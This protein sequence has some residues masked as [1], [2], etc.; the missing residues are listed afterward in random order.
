MEIYSAAAAADL[1]GLHKEKMIQLFKDWI[2]FF[3][4]NLLPAVSRNDAIAL[5]SSLSYLLSHSGRSRPSE[6][7]SYHPS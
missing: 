4:Y 7:K 3:S 6:M 2:I 5:S 1:F